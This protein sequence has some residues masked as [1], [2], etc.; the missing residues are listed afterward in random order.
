[1]AMN[2][3]KTK[4]KEDSMKIKPII[5]NSEA[6]SRDIIL[7]EKFGYSMNWLLGIKML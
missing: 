1:M 6:D 4:I 5:A 7:I 3:I 2:A